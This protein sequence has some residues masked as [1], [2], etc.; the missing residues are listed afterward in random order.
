MAKICITCCEGQ[1]WYPTPVSNFEDYL[2]KFF[3]TGNGIS[4]TYAIRKN[5]AY[6]LQYIEFQLK[7]LEE[8]DPSSVIKTQ[9]W[10]MC[11]VVGI[12]IIEAFLYYLL[13]SKSEIK[14]TPWSTDPDIKIENTKNLDGVEYKIK[15]LF[16]KKGTLALERINL[17]GMIKIV[18]NKRILGN[19][20]EI[21]KKLNYLRKRRNKIHLH[22]VNSGQDTDWFNFNS[23][24]IKTLK[25]VLHVFLTSTYFS[26]TK[27]EIEMFK[28]LK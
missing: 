22:L 18:Q 13:V 14:K 15:N 3:I 27:A 25:Q 9:T 24:D 5:I 28:F 23:D 1:K 16:F 4:G 11:I 2:K 26:P 7:S 17:D 21:Y 8:F 12:G 19:G 6:N 20:V 10:K